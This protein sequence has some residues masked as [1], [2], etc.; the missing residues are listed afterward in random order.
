LINA[1]HITMLRLDNTCTMHLFILGTFM[2]FWIWSSSIAPWSYCFAFLSGDFQFQVVK[3]WSCPLLLVM[4][5]YFC[6]LIQWL[7]RKN[8]CA[9]SWF[10]CCLLQMLYV[11]HW[12]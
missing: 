4:F 2:Y 10:W 3:C 9:S 5:Y 1:W 7:E 6:L 12:G 11:C 8:Y